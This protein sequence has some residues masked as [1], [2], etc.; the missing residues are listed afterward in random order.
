MHPN[1]S[2]RYSTQFRLT[3]LIRLWVFL[4][5]MVSM[6]LHAS[7]TEILHFDDHQCKAQLKQIR[8]TRDAPELTTRHWV[9]VNLPDRWEN[10]WKGY[11]G[12]VWYQIRWSQQCDNTQNT[13]IA[14]AI[15]SISMAGEVYLN[16]H[17]IWKDRAL[18]EPLSRSWNAPRYWML[19]PAHFNAGLNQLD[20]KVVGVATQTPGLG[21]THL[22]QPD[23]VIAKHEHY[24]L[25]N[26]TLYFVNLVASLTL[27]TITFIIWLL[28]SKE[29]TFGW[30]ALTSFF[31]ALFVYNILSFDIYPF[32]STIAY[33][34]FNM[35]LLILYSLCFITF[36]WRF[37]NRKF[38]K[39]E[40][41]LW[42]IA[43]AIWLYIAFASNNTLQLALFI[44]FLYVVALFLLNCIAFQWIALKSEQPEVR[45]LALVFLLYIVIC[46]HDVTKILLQHQTGIFITPFSAP[47]MTLAISLIL[48][49]RIARN[50]NHI[51]N[52][53]QQLEYNIEQTKLELKQSLDNKHQ[54][55]IENIRLQERIHLSHELHDGL[56]GSLVRSMFLVDKAEQFDKQQF[57]SIL[58]LLRNDLRQIID[59]GSSI[60]VT[61]PESPIIWAAPLRR[62]F[63]EIF[64]ELDIHSDWDIPQQWPVQPTALEF[65]TMARVTEE[66]LTNV[67]KHS[68]AK[69]VLI[70]LVCH[71]HHPQEMVLNIED[72]GIGFDPT[73]VQTGLHVGLH[74]MQIRVQRI[75]GILK[76]QSQPGRT[77]IEVILCRQKHDLSQ[78]H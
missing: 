21:E 68:R 42:S 30:F 78:P 25:F 74:S 64:D 16:Q 61:V 72:D 31:W 77:Q 55:E 11:S 63:V 32:S 38:K 34:K 50:M 70:S 35:C 44:G 76:I 1:Q 45:F 17:L 58:K 20:I 66:T 22:G 59:S 37:A 3:R 43:I 26:R 2:C 7:P 39:I 46:I 53:N 75:G 36:S 10:R 40:I 49:W 60:G 23:I 13:P 67:L 27:S 9:D 19:S 47:L 12:P 73:K 52:F 51:E 14:L 15:H 65:L 4:C 71:R 69:N 8:S 28:R 54:L 56:G 41:L 62:R 18:V 57:M 6:S 5:C 24:T 29:S 48:A 33:S